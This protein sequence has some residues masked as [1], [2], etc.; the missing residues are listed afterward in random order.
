M[1]EQKHAAKYS[2]YYLLSLAALIFVG[3]SLG[4]IAFGIIDENIVDPL[5]GDYYRNINGSFRFA[6]SA[7]IIATPIYYYMS[8]LIAK[9][10]KKEELPADSAIRKWLTYFIIF[11]SALIILGV[12]ISV[13][14]NFLAGELTLKSVL[15]ALTVFLIAGLVFSY[16]F[17][18]IRQEK[19][20]SVKLNKV[21][22]YLSLFIIVSAFISAWFF[23]ESPKE[24]RN[25]KLDDIVIQRINSLENLVNV[26]YEETGLIPESMDELY[27]INKN[28]AYVLDEKYFL[29]PE[30]AEAIEYKK[31]NDTEFE[32]C[33]NFRSSSEAYTRNDPYS[34]HYESGYQCLSGHLWSRA[35]LKD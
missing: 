8:F 32:F 34:K 13:I 2:F 15:Q 1:T 35:L 6:I 7:L 9:G 29:D 31:I 20:I 26:H 12:F 10:L 24:A 16:Y 23:V 3:I 22:F 27:A 30:S 17:Y 25:R 18:D 5:V 33:A 11:V 19:S 21:F 28:S 4:L 14:N